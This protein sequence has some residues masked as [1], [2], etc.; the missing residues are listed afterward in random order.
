LPVDDVNHLKT[1]MDHYP[2]VS[3][4]E[5]EY[6]SSASRHDSASSVNNRAQYHSP[7]E[8]IHQANPKQTQQ[9]NM[10]ESVSTSQP[11]L[12]TPP[13]RKDSV[14][15]I[16]MDDA[17]EKELAAHIAQYTDAP[18][19]YSQKQYEGKSEDEVSQMRMVDYAKEI[20]RQMGRQLMRGVKINSGTK[21]EA[22]S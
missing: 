11:T 1:S 15:A 16:S 21:D 2:E 4:S 13:E 7:P 8:V 20:S 12:S 17:G 19:P 10:S 3:V 22:K 18:P 6:P 5:R 9:T 14:Q